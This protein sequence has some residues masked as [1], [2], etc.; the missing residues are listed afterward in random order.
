MP[1]TFRIQAKAS[2]KI[3]A[4]SSKFSNYPVVG[5]LIGSIEESVLSDA[6]PLFHSEILPT[7]ALEMAMDLISLHYDGSDMN[8]V[9]LYFGNKV[10]LDKSIH[11][12]VQLLATRIDKMAGGG[13]IILRINPANLIGME[14]LVLTNGNWT[15][16][17]KIDALPASKDDYLL[18]SYC[19]VVDFEEHLFNT[20][21][22]WIGNNSFIG[23]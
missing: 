3:I 23:Q 5:I 16:T 13:S 6:I 2:R 21:L 19:K 20:E 14:A 4:H 7:P 10:L 22:D 18:D 1:N 15:E 11:P 17:E 9:G 8:I 12:G